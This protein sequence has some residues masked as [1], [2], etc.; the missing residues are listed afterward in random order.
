MSNLVTTDDGSRLATLQEAAAN[1][2]RLV[3]ER[4]LYSTSANGFLTGSDTSRS[5]PD[6]VN[7]VDGGTAPGT[8]ATSVRPASSTATTTTTGTR[9]HRYVL[10]LR[11]SESY[12]R[13]YRRLGST[14]GLLGGERESQR[15]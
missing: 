14:A 5:L 9:G 8:P 6:Y 1:G 10:N 7:P 13:Y 15:P 12:T 11:E 3:R 2:A 4:S